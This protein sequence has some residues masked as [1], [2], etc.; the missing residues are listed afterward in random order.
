M[1]DLQ[2]I[3]TLRDKTGAGMMDCQ[4]VLEET[5][6]N[7]EQAIEILRK[8]GEKIAAKKADRE[9]KEGVVAV[10]KSGNKVAVVALNCETDFVARNE[11]FI[12]TVNEFAT[13]LLEN[14]KEG[15][16]DW[17]EGK[18]KDELIVKI[19]ENLKLKDFDLIEG[20]VVDYYLH[21]NNKLASVVVLKGSD[22]ELAKDIAMHVTAMKPE[23]LQ[24]VDVPTETV[25][26]EKEIYKEQLKKEDKPADIIEKIIEGKL[27]KFYEET[28]LVKQKYIK[29]DSMTI[30][31][32]L[33]SK[34]AEIEKFTRYFL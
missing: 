14:G 4:R 2:Q 25:S 24:V 29:D 23:Y 21:S 8:K 3:K 19:G 26:K 13:Y 16:S 15:F 22:G 18:I 12:S 34:G 33:E 32:L 5:N 1:V 30:E 6:G 28:C 27:N 20:E 9:A 11:E 17:A 7:I 31:K 10:Q